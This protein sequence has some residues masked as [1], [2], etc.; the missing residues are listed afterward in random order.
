MRTRAPQ[1]PSSCRVGSWWPPGGAGG[2]QLRCHA[3]SCRP[4]PGRLAHQAT[5]NACMHVLAG[6]P[7]PDDAPMMPFNL[8]AEREVG[9]R[10]WTR[11]GGGCQTA[12][13]PPPWKSAHTAAVLAV[14]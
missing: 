14:S 7:G 5:A 8:K 12:D 1:P 11:G 2:A 13:P 9:S 4:D 10:G 3:R 6:A